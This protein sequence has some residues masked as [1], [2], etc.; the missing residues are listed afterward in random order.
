M[1]RRE[2]SFGAA[3]LLVLVLYGLLGGRTV[4]PLLPG[5]T[6][7]PT[8]ARPSAP[9]AAPR[10]AGT[11]AFS[12]R[13][14]VYLLREGK[15]SAVTSESRSLSPSLSA[16]GRTLLLTRRETIEGRRIVDGQTT[17][18]T[19][20]Y[21]DIVKKDPA[22][23]AETIVLTG[24]RV[25]ASSG[26]HEVAW[27]DGPAISPDGTRFAVVVDVGDGASELEVYDM[28]STAARPVRLLKLSAGSDLADPSWSPD[29][30]TL[31]VTSY[32]LGA[33]RLLIVPT[34]GRVATPQ[35]MGAK[36]EAYRPSYSP[37]GRWL[38]YTLRQPTGSNDVHAVELATGRDVAV[39]SDGKSWNGVFSPDGGSIAFLRETAGAIDLYAMELNNLLT[40]GGP[41][42][43]AVKLTHGEG[44]DGQSRLAWGR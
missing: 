34:D 6:I 19:L 37:D 13:G 12:L 20:H 7:S 40:G 43:A 44:I 29:G 27:Q 25:R 1:R 30:K 17:P 22:S 21:T 38:V 16:D 35:K 8:P 23:G 28:R 36:G 31:V 14:D 5:G 26:F 18:A 15:Y 32:T 2:A 3:A 10:I 33:P 42:K 41:P 24:L 4:A 39:T 11:I 9:V